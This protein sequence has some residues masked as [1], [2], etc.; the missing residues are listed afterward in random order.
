MSDGSAQPV[1][2]DFGAV[3]LVLTEKRGLEPPPTMEKSLGPEGLGV[4]ILRVTS[5]SHADTCNVTVPWVPSRGWACPARAA[6]N[7]SLRDPPGAGGTPPPITVVEL[8][9]GALSGAGTSG[10]PL[11]HTQPYPTGSCNVTFTV[12]AKDEFVAIADELVT[13]LLLFASVAFAPGSQMLTPSPPGIQEWQ[14]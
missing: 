9:T 11:S 13:L 8:S 6:V 12:I 4:V 14:V 2:D 3:K 1:P 5:I 7:R 10:S